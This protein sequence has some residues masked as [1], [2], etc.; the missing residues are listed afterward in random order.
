MALDTQLI[1]L[2]SGTE[3]ALPPDLVHR[4]KDYM[5]N[6]RSERTREAYSR[7]WRVFTGWCDRLGRQALPAEPET[8]A[9]WLV[10]LADGADGARPLSRASINQALAAITLA[11]RTAGFPFDRKHRVIAETWAGISRVKA[12][13]EVERQAAPFLAADVRDTLGLL[14]TALNSGC[15]DAALLTLG[16]GAALR[17]SELVS[18]DFEELGTGTGYVRIDER[19]ILI[20]L[21]RSK[22]SQ[23]EAETVVIPRAD[24]PEACEALEAWA[25]RVPLAA[26][27]PIFRGVN[28]RD[29]I[30]A[31]RLTA[32]SVARAVKRAMADLARSRGKSKNEA[33]D[34]VRR[35]SGHSLRAGYATSAA[36]A[37]VP[38]LRIQQHTRHKSADMVSKYVR[39][40]DKW[41][42]S[43]LKG[44]LHRTARPAQ[45][46]ASAK[47][48]EALGI[49]ATVHTRDD[50]MGFRIVADATPASFE[51]SDY[52]EAWRTVREHLGMQCG[53]ISVSAPA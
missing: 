37:D 24:L 35:F 19:G 16:W 21:A 11:H 33:K 17:R 20:T 28:N 38:A 6:A 51:A 31:E 1:P 53:R 44:I 25:K 5:A 22:G 43:G 18:L 36:D 34:L 52:A 2:P 50:E 42:K 14:N 9:A 3:I 41:R 8:A 4:T 48:D 26:G 12:M 13:V 45:R 30:A 46:G 27:E 23:D 47:L 29:Q 10:A 7:W 15:R 39:T 40:T 49:L 32:P